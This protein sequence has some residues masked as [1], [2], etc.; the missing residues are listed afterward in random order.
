MT[1]FGLFDKIDEIIV[2]VREHADLKE[3]DVQKFYTSLF[4]PLSLN[5]VQLQMWLALLE[6]YPESFR[7]NK[8]PDLAVKD[9]LKHI[10][11]EKLPSELGKEFQVDGLM[12][13]IH[14]TLDTE[15]ESLEKLSKAFPNLMKEWNGRK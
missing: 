5:L 8:M 2:K 7:E 6:K 3:F 11:N 4:L 13:N 9:V 1:C 12:I 15:T 14:L 10:L